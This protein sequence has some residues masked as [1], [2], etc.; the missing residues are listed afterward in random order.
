MVS[1]CL[2]KA[3]VLGRTPGCRNMWRCR[4]IYFTTDKERGV[5][6]GVRTN[7]LPRTCPTVPLLQ[8]DSY[9]S[10]QNFPKYSCQM[11]LYLTT[12]AFDS[13][14]PNQGIPTSVQFTLW[15][16]TMVIALTLLLVLISTLLK[17]HLSISP[18]LLFASSGMLMQRL[19]HL[20]LLALIVYPLI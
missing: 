20:Y 9:K 6:R 12:L 13:L 5:T 19:F 8:L 14:S 11:D 17:Y 3:L 4:M 18:L 10:F 15:L 2:L 7:T 1:E 16:V